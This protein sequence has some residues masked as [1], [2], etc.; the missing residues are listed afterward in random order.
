MVGQSFLGWTWVVV[1]NPLKG[2]GGRVAGTP[3]R[4]AT[5]GPGQKRTGVATMVCEMEGSSQRA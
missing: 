5:V 4:L 3:D 1:G 2:C